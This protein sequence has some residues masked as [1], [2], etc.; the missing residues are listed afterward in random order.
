[1]RVRFFGTRGSIAAPLGAGDVAE[2]VRR[3]L[4]SGL[5]RSLRTPEDV[6]RFMRTHLSFSTT[7]TFGGQTSCVQ[8][9]SDE[10]SLVLDMGTGLRTLGSELMARNPQ[11]APMHVDIL[12]SHPHW[13]H[14]AGFPFFAPLTSPSTTV[15][16]HA[17]HD[18][19]EAAL[20]RQHGDPSFPVPFDQIAADVSFARLE[21]GRTTEIGGFAVTPMRQHHE[22]DSFAY[23]ID[24][25]TR[26]LVYA[27][28]TEF[29]DGTPGEAEEAAAFF[30]DADMVVFDA[31]YTLAEAATDRRRFGHASNVQGAD[32][33]MRA[34][35]RRLCLFHHDPRRRDDELQR[36]LDQTRRY[37]A[38]QGADD[39]LEV[40]AAHDGLD[41]VLT[42]GVVT[43]PRACTEPAA[44]F[45]RC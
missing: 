32:I 8:I 35:A 17:C 34:G 11:R 43:P 30:A 4:V 44:G 13:D 7:G 31:M 29:L 9:C 40:I 5:G 45:A 26:T 3:A 41:Y 2:K 27:T 42:D 22:G 6:D 19:I 1:M 18:T 12:L 36:L 24:D 38:L 14:I 15:T 21:P 33:C 25:G 16:I 28:D 20:R 39:T 37:V 23:R 10:R